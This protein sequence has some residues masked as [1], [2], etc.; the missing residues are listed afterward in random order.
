MEMVPEWGWLL[1]IFHQKSRGFSYHTRLLN[2]QFEKSPTRGT[3]R[4]RERTTENRRVYG[5]YNNIKDDGFDYI[6]G[7]GAIHNSPNLSETF[8]HF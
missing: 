6:F 2:Q 3:V 1:H 8:K 4:L 7:F 5:T